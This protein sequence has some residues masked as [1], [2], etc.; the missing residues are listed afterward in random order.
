MSD[1][2]RAEDILSRTLDRLEKAKIERDSPEGERSME[3]AC[4]IFKAWTGISLCEEDG[5]R[6]MICLKQ[7]REYQGSFIADDY[8]DIAG[9]SALLA[10]CE[11]RY[12][13]STKA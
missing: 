9:Y 12:A 1:K 8:V 10:E 6:F 5:W 7:A 3:K 4:N 2:V 11:S 13:E